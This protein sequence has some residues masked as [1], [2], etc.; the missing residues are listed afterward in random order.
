[1]KWGIL[2]AALVVSWVAT[3][4]VLS[5][6][7]EVVPSVIIVVGAPGE[8]LFEEQFAAWGSNWWGAAETARAKRQAVGLTNSPATNQLEQ[9][10]LM[11]HAE[12]KNSSSPLWLILIGHGT[13]DNQ[14]AK[15]NLRGPDLTATT[16]SEWL[17]EFHRPIAILNTFSASGPFMN[18]LSGPGR[19]VITATRSG[20]EQNYSRFGKYLSE[21]LLSGDADLDKD[22]R[23]SLL[24]CYLKA[25][26]D[27]AEFYRTQG[28]LATEHPL[29]DD[30]GDGLGTPPDWFRGIRAVKK[31]KDDA[32]LDG[33]RAHQLHLF[34]DAG[35]LALSAEARTRRDAIEQQI[36]A[37]R[38]H[39]AELKE[40]D[41]YGQ[42]EKLL[43]EL[44]MLYR[45]AQ[46]PPG[47]SS[48]GNSRP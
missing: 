42:L 22:G 34:S 35:E 4:E 27:L 10:R 32:S 29:L 8:D 3:A 12:Q 13:F 5:T 28:R 7:Q 31:A 47:T 44:A 30:N 33:M 18:K 38:Q 26:R 48:G 14:E 6:N 39:K 46:K 16:L 25:A 11:L 15:F 2:S 17:K 41:Y 24:E 20:T 36:E 37:L 45:G 9:L 19:V 40:D 23:V 43:V 1:M 21:A